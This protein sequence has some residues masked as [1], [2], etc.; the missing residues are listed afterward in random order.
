MKKTEEFERDLK[1]AYLNYENDDLKETLKYLDRILEE[2]LKEDESLENDPFWK[3]LTCDVFKAVLLNNFYNKVELTGNDL[4]SLLVNKDE[5]KI[6]VQEFCKNF[7]D[8]SLI[9]FISHVENITDNSLE[10]TIEILMTNIG[11]MNISGVKAEENNGDIIEVIDNQSLKTTSYDTNDDTENI[12]AKESITYFKDGQDISEERNIFVFKI[13]SKDE[14]S[15]TIKTN[16]MCE[17]IDDKINLINPKTEFKLY[18]NKE[19]I[20]STPTMDR[21]HTFKLS[22]KTKETNGLDKKY[23]ELS[24]GTFVNINDLESLEPYS[25]TSNNK[26]GDDSKKYS[27]KDNIVL[28]AKI[29]TDW[30]IKNKDFIILKE[31]ITI[32]YGNNHDEGPYVENLVCESNFYYSIGDSMSFICEKDG[33]QFTL[34]PSNK[35]IRI[36]NEDYNIPKIEIHNY[37]PEKLGLINLD[38]LNIK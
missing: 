28:P 17:V 7:K 8:N 34:I 26:Y 16:P 22:I 11:K 24:S 37:D 6:N 5:I 36:N 9:D 2:I 12:V 29:A 1:V 10:S 3:A 38:K 14:N 20:L 30:I 32:M 15:I 33:E 27:P 23:P 18:K 19:L 35:W 13:V 31:N 4:D 25:S 21:A